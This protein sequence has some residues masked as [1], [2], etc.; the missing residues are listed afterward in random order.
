VGEGEGCEGVGGISLGA[1]DCGAVISLGRKT[2]GSRTHG[3][4]GGR[5]C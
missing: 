4:R 5:G 1:E 2:W 3:S